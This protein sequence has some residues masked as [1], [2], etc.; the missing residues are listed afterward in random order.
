[1]VRHSMSIGIERQIS[2]GERMKTYEIKTIISIER[3]HVVEAADEEGAKALAAE[4]TF[5]AIDETTVDYD[6]DVYHI[7]R[8]Q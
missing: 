1:M 6:Y 7:T 5:N 2:N 4:L 8:S 3:T